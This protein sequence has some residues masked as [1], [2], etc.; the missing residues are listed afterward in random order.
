MMNI[1]PKTKPFIP[2]I[3]VDF[4]GTIHSYTSGWQG[5][6]KI[7]DPPVEGAFDWLRDMLGTPEEISVMLHEPPFADICIYST[8]NKNPFAIMAMRKW[9]LKHGLEPCYIRLLRF[10]FTKP[11]AYITID[12]RAVTFEGTFP[13]L[14]QIL[15]FKPWYKR[16]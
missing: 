4:D 1:T 3:A 13:D 15:K 12:D 11:S 10:P 8:R 16:T 7:P 2:T 6:T 5:R 14:D 9:F